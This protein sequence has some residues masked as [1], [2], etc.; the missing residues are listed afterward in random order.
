MS[1]RRLPITENKQ[2]AWANKIGGSVNANSIIQ[3]SGII[4]DYSPYGTTISVDPSNEPYAIV[5]R[6]EFDINQEYYP[7]QIV[8]VTYGHT[9]INQNNVPLPYGNTSEYSSSLIPLNP[10]LFICTQY[11]PPATAT[12][13]WL[14]IAQGYLPGGSIPASMPYGIRFY[15]YNVYY[16]IYPEIPLQFT[17]SVKIY[18]GVNSIVANQTYWNALPFGTIAL[19]S[20]LNNEKTPIF[21]QGFISGSNFDQRYLPYTP[22]A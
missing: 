17:S 9:Q 4:V 13:A 16:P 6:G 2:N 20:C 12:Q 5:Y 18:D 19:N 1:I 15:Q 14:G 8:R 3:G 11:V 21:V 22:P 10:G 7:N